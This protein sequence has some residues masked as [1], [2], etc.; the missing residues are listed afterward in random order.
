M[1]WYKKN[2]CSH[3]IAK[4]YTQNTRSW[5]PNTYSYQQYT[6]FWPGNNNFLQKKYQLAATKR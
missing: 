6:V 2:H 3:K 1:T 4:L 5:P